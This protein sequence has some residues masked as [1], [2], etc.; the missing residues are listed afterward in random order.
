MNCWITEVP[1]SI[2]SFRE[3]HS[4]DGC[5]QSLSCP[6]GARLPALSRVTPAKV[7]LCLC[8]IQLSLLT[9]VQAAPYIPNAEEVVMRVPAALIGLPEDWMSAA[10]ESPQQAAGYA[11]QW[12][13]AARKTSNPRYFAYARSSL[14]V[15]WDAEDVPAE[16]LLIRADLK[17]HAHDFD[18][19]L[20]DLAD[21]QR[22]Y[23][24]NT[25]GYIQSY[26]M[27]AHIYMAQ[28]FYQQAKR[29]CGQLLI[30]APE[31][32]SLCF[33]RASGY[34]GQADQ[35]RR[36]ISRLQ[37]DGDNTALKIEAYLTLAEAAQLS[38][39]LQEAEKYYR[40]VLRLNPSHAYA[41]ISLGWLLIE[42]Q[43]FAQLLANVP[44]NHPSPGIRVLRVIA[45]K[46]LG[47]GD[48]PDQLAALESLFA[49]QPQSQKGRDFGRYL[50]DL[51]GQPEQACKV[52]NDN[53]QKQK[54]PA[55]LHLVVDCAVQTGNQELLWSMQSWVAQ[56]GLVDQQLNRKL[57][58]Y[59]Q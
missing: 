4:R 45:L 11:G 36:F 39:D 9:P 14:K 43:Q 21:Y 5:E 22:Y 16:V 50:L 19:A 44:E 58:R 54:E 33:A 38:G 37:T 17:Q 29:V 59:S 13:E 51:R 52:A 55:D 28:G 1:G 57:N 18:G 40:Q 47:S 31:M 23:P 32:A 24:G 48:Y 2:N 26:D 12:I 49:S 42:S 7:L 53:W 10:T 25:P 27:M 15:W 8:L 35:T 3:G 41:L 46:R 6:E 20:A 34:T 30:L 56:S